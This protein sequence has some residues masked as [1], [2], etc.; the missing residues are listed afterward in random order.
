MDKL[1]LG[2]VL[3]Q[4]WDL[5]MKDIV[6]LIVGGLIVGV[7]S[8]V[9]LFILMPVLNAGLYKMVIRRVKEGR[10]AE[11]GDVFSCFDQFGTLFVTGLVC[12]LLIMLGTILCIIPGLLLATIWIYTTPLILEKKVG[13]GAAL[14]MSKEMVTKNGFGPHLVILLV[15]MVL[16]GAANAISG[17]LAGI[18]ATP[19]MVAVI[20]AM[21]FT[22]EGV[23][24]DG[25]Q[26]APATPYPQ[27]PSAPPAAGRSPFAGPPPAAPQASPVASVASSV[28]AG[29]NQAGQEINKAVN[30]IQKPAAPAAPPAARPAAKL[31]CKSCNADAPAAGAFCI[32][33]GEPLK[34]KCSGCSGELIPGAGF[35]THCG[36]K[37]K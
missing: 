34:V 35:C 30:D 22:L 16:M 15:L 5:M 1:D 6:P 33:C 18:L 12:G 31:V 11:I 20:M 7:L 4:G 37:L 23:P 24:I 28:V 27:S 17:G 21:Y 10:T 9:T 19:F 26:P 2:K 3:K 14:R 32:S 36:A 29:L 8:V 13:M 25:G